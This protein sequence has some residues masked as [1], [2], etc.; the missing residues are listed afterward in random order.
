[1][2]LQP[3]A[4]GSIEKEKKKDRFLFFH[5]FA[6]QGRKEVEKELKQTEKDNAA[7]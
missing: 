1:L 7:N 2:T 4:K 5:P 3:A 6:A